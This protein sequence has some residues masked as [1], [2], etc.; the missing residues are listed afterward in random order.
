ML[1]NIFCKNNSILLKVFLLAAALVFL[2]FQQGYGQNS[3]NFQTMLQKAKEGDAKAQ[4]DLGS[5][6][7]KGKEVPQNIAEALKWYR[8]AADQGFAKA[9][10][11]LGAMY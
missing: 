7:S 3:S 9:Q 5:M 2:S 10:C 6:Y 1:L 4:N 11:N 8:T